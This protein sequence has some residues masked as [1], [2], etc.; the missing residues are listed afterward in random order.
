MLVIS[1][2]D[3]PNERIEISDRKKIPQHEGQMKKVSVIIPVF[4][5]RDYIDETLSSIEQQTLRDIEIICVDDASSDG[6]T[7]IL[8]SHLRK[9]S[10]I[11]LIEHKENLGTGAAIN[12]GIAMSNGEYVQIVGNDDLLEPDALDF[13]YNYCSMYALD[14]CQYGITAFV[15]DEADE[16]L[17]NR[18]ERVRRYHEVTHDYPICS[19]V[20]LLKLLIS[21]D[22]YR[23]NNGPMIVKSTMLTGLN[24]NIEGIRHEDMHYVYKMLLFAKQATI[25]GNKLYR[26]RMRRGSQE[27]AKNT[28]PYSEIEC[29]SLII[30][31]FEMLKATPIQL[32]NDES[33]RPVIE[34]Q[35][36]HYLNNGVTKYTKLDDEEREKIETN[37]DWRV[38]A[39]LPLLREIKKNR[40]E[41]TKAKKEVERLEAKRLQA[42]ERIDELKQSKSY[43]IGR[44]ITYLPRKLKHLIHSFFRQA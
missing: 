24:T 31:S 9:D 16:A 12:S 21:N 22:E 30:S 27:D 4:N 19:G 43:R 14:V 23:M 44:V 17:L 3:N 28:K 33:F 1:N 41:L 20:E 37:N 10:R 13:L 39:C 32:R 2:G 34:S 11:S 35:I 29:S 40:L 8:K 36:Y 15:D 7:G 5:A 25:I 18:C 26:Y 42:L 6:S 38:L